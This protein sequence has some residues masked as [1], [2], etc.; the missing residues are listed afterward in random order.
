LFRSP[1]HPYTEALLQAADVRNAIHSEEIVV[2]QSPSLTDLPRG[3]RFHPRCRY[4]MDRCRT[5]SPGA[6]R[7]NG[8]G[9]ARCWLRTSPQPADNDGRTVGEVI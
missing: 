4:A 7:I 1:Q 8:S 6:F 9:W 3:C 5:E 2:G